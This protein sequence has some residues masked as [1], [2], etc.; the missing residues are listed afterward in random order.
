MRRTKPAAS[1]EQ[2]REIMREASARLPQRH[3][4]DTDP[5]DPSQHLDDIGGI[6]V[7]PLAVEARPAAEASEDFDIAAAEN[8]EGESEPE[9]EEP[10][11]LVHDTGELYGVRTPHAGD[12]D[13]AAP[14]D[15]DSFEGASRGETWLEALEE[16]AAE[17]GPAPEEEVVIVDDSDVEHPDHRGHHPTDWRDR[18]VA[19]K[20]SG[21]PGGL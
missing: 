14:E 5:E 11:E 7:E 15:Q 21:G 4:V 2:H 1:N 20:G 3:L 10:A 16:H 9:D 19:D 18:P 17:M 12:T 13:L 6:D 8:V